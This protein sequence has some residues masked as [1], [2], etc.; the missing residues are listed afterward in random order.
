MCSPGEHQSQLGKDHCVPCDPGTFAS[1]FG[2]D[3]CSPCDPGSYAAVGGAQACSKCG[4]ATDFKTT[5]KEVDEVEKR[6]IEVQ[7]A[8]SESYCRC[9]WAQE[10]RS[11]EV[12]S[13]SLSI[14]V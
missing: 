2:Q 4:D 9:A 8:T 11:I 14:T 10:V 5:M 13:E 12:R 1:N 3:L 7:G 6:W